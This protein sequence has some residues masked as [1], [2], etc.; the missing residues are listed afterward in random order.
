[1]ID[2]DAED[3]QW[4]MVT[5]A[6]CGRTGRC[7]PWTDYYET[8]LFPDGRVCEGCFHGLVHDHMVYEQDVASHSKRHRDDGL[9]GA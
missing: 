2:Y 8:P 9:G 7:T 4:Q 5:C 1:M 3:I 6:K